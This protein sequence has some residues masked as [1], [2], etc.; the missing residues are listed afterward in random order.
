MQ[1]SPNEMRKRKVTS[2]T[3]EEIKQQ[4]DASFSYVV[5]ERAGPADKSRLK[6]I[7][8]ALNSTDLPVLELRTFYDPDRGKML[9]VAKFHAERTEGI[10]EALIGA[11]LPDDVVIYGY[12]SSHPGRENKA[13]DLS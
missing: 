3:L 1:V 6:V 12:G 10:M 11:G 5:F 13:E 7:F 4:F 9:L 2:S 8:N